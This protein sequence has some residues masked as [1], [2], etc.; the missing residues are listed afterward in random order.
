MFSLEEAYKEINIDEIFSKVS[1]YELWKYYCP[2]FESFDRSFTS[3]FY[4]DKVPSCRIFMSNSNK[5]MYKDF[6]TKETYDIIAYIMRKYGTNFKESLKII[7]NDFNIRKLDVK[8]NQ[9][10]LLKFD[11][12]NKPFRT[13]IEIVSQPFTLKDSVYWGQYGIPLTLLQTYNVFSCKSA[14]II[15][16]NKLTILNYVNSPIYAYRFKDDELKY[17]YKLYLPFKNKEFR[18]LSNVTTQNIEGY[19]QLSLNCDTLIIT[20]SLKDCMVLRVMGYDAISLQSENNKLDPD[21]ASEMIHRYKNIY[22]LYDND[23]TGIKNSQELSNKYGFKCLYVD[24]YKDISDY[25]K[26]NGIENGLLM[27]KNKIN[28]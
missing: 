6:G 9:T 16:N 17:S 13:K 28:E 2:K 27:L 19:E 7:A 12:E 22:I 11:D 8:K 14:H 5:L 20:K 23:E 26:D 18:F 24:D 15:K 1:E 4:Q 21:L 3:D 10:R 25:V